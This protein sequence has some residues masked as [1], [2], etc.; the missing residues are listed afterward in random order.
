[1]GVDAF[2]CIVIAFVDMA[3]DPVSG[4]VGVDK[5]PEAIKALVSRIRQVTVACNGGVGKDDIH[6]LVFFQFPLQLADTLA[7]LP[8]RVLMLTG[9][10]FH[11]AAQ[12]QDPQTFV[13]H[14]LVFDIV[15]AQRG[16]DLIAFVVIAVDIKNGAAGHGDDK[17]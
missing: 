17:A 12:T 6:T 16:L 9:A 2:H 4:A 1:M 8:F 13:N 10:V 5:L 7:H 3:V 14:D 11:T 15:A